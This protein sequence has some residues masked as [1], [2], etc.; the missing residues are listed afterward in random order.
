M[1][2]I[3]LIFL[4]FL[5]QNGSN[6]NVGRYYDG[7]TLLQYA[8]ECGIEE[9]VRLLQKIWRSIDT[10]SKIKLRIQKEPKNLKR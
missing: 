4:E 3:C 2:D 1:S 5:L 8:K 9:A 6:P 10:I 7:K